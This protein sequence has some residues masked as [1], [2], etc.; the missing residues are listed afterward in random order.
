MTTEQ[1]APPDSRASELLPRI[2]ARPTAMETKP[3]NSRIVQ[4]LV[5]MMLL[6]VSQ[7]WPNV[8]TLAQQQPP[9]LIARTFSAAD[10]STILGRDVVDKLGVD[11][12]PLVDVLADRSGRPVAGVIDVGGFLGLG[13][14][15]IAVGWRLLR[16]VTDSAGT[17]IQMDLT[18][19]AAAAAPEFQSSD[20]SLI[21]IDN[22]PP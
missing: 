10:I 9:A 14:R 15:R 4:T 12:G 18:F 17:R 11:V 19:D 13:R 20:G 16:L 6:A 2:V 5:G 1:R 21:V 3:R 22:Q 7:C 8:E